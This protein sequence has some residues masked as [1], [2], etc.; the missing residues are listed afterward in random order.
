MPKGVVGTMDTLGW[1]TE[2]SLK[3]NRKIAYWFATR[4]DQSTV[5]RNVE[6]FQFIKETLQGS[7]APL[8]EFKK[9]IK[10]SLM[11]LLLESFDDVLIEINHQNVTNEG[12]IVNMIISGYCLENENTYDIA[13]SVYVNNKTYELIDEGRH[14]K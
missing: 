4:K 10:R 3:I 12:S 5:I 6:S 13:Y 7:K 2:P 14:G 8:S 11:N 1:V 9:T